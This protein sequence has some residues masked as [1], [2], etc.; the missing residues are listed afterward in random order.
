VISVR[1]GSGE[2]STEMPGHGCFLRGG[3]E[4]FHTYST[5]G[6][7][8]EYTPASIRCSTSPLWAGRKAW[9]E[10]TGHAPV[11]HEI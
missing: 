6:R 1:A 2:R 7:G 10:P 11:P 9:E 4:I 8:N 3:N 5:Y